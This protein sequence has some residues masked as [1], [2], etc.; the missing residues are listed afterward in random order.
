METDD[1]HALLNDAPQ[2][3][4]R[5]GRQG[6]DSLVVPG[7]RDPAFLRDGAS[8]RLRRCPGPANAGSREGSTARPVAEARAI[9]DSRICD[10]SDHGPRVL[11][12]GS[13][14]VS[15][16]GLLLENDLHPP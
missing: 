6:R 15:K 16:W 13:K 5:M 2:H 8:G 12:R 4:V 7:F 11:R 9:W 14:P 1:D 10:Q 3:M